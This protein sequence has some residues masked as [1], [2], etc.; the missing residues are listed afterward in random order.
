M[1]RIALG[2]L[3]VALWLGAS[4]CTWT[5]TYQ[6]YPPGLSADQAHHHHDHDH[7]QGHADE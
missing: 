5:Q 4:G 6:Q 7:G 3:T 2:L 1:A